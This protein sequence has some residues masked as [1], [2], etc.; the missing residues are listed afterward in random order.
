MSNIFSFERF[1]KVLKYDL[2]MRVPAIGIF[3]LV[4]LIMPHV[5]HQMMD[6]GNIFP[7]DQRFDLCGVM[8]VFVVFFAPFKIYT[9][10]RGKQELGSYLMLPASSLEKF[11]SMVLVSLVLVPVSF[12]LSCYLLD[13][14][15][16][17]LFS[18]QYG[19]VVI[20]DYMLLLRGA[21]AMFALT[22]AAILGNTLFKKGA[23]GKTLLC[24]LIL[25]LLWTSVIASKFFDM[26]LGEGVVAVDP[27]VLRLWGDITAIAY[28]AGATLFYIL[29]WW[30]I[31]KIQ[32][33]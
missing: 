10:F 26:L 33:S 6:F 12:V 29:A 19:S 21:Y 22:G 30:R 24:M 18:G 4:L 3:F 32:I 23:P 14:I 9:A 13:A 2:V 17:L 15:L 8:C 7:V 28:F 27:E 16:C 1:L 31:R 5:L 11:V 20:V 25:V